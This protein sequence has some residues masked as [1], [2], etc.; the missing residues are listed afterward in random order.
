MKITCPQCEFSREVA[1]EK[2]PSGSFMATCPQ[3]QHR[4]KIANNTNSLHSSTAPVDNTHEPKHSDSFPQQKT[5]NSTSQQA[6]SSAASQQERKDEHKANP[7]QQQAQQTQKPQE[8]AS[9]QAENTAQEYDP[10]LAFALENPWDSPEKYGYFSA[11]YQAVMRILFSAPRFFFGLTAQSPMHR[12]FLFYCI[13]SILQITFER[14]WG[15]VIS[16]SLTP[17]AANDPNLQVLLTFL[18]PKGSYLLIILLGTAFS[19]IELIFSTA[20]FTLLFSFIARDKGSYAL[21]FQIVA[22]SSAP[23]L[24]CVVPLIGSAVGFVWGI[25]TTLIGCRY[26]LRLDWPRTL[27][28]V[29]PIYL[30]GLYIA[31]KLMTGW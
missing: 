11:F 18:N 17:L 21:F 23:M 3:C 25:A 20:I 16:E 13:I 8:H 30:I 9:E 4:F 31:L 27:L 19:I 6:S 14:F 1:K 15:G 26:A 28:G 22:Y 24:L 2:M 5:T 12:A 10:S 7:L 29:L